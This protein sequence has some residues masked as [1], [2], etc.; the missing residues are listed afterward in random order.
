MKIEI[1]DM[2]NE[3]VIHS[4]NCS[5]RTAD[6]VE[7]GI[8]IKMSK[9]KNDFGDK[10]PKCK[11]CLYLGE[12]PTWAEKDGWNIEGDFDIAECRR[13]PPTFCN[14]QM[15]HPE[16]GVYPIVF[17]DCYWCGEWCLNTKNRKN[18]NAG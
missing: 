2:K 14:G 16:Y 18:A 5:T 17:V 13:Y 6:K 11:T 8:N 15:T 12:K 1:V 7:N 10:T 9:K 3:K 4:V